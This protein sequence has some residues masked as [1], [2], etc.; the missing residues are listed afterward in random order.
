MSGQLWSAR[1]YEAHGR[2]VSDLGSP[3]VD[4]LEPRPGERIL[5]VGCGDGALTAR[6]VERGAAVVGVDASEDFVRAARERGLDARL[7]DARALTFAGEFDA[8]FSNAVLHW[9]D[10][11]EPVLEGVHRALRPGGRFVGE[12][13]GFGNVAAITTAMR[14]VAAR[15]R[16]PLS[17]PWRFP[18]AEAFEAQLAA[19]GFDDTRA[20][21]LP[22][23][24]A[25][26]SGMADWLRTFANGVF[27]DVAAAEREAALEEVEE[28]L[29]PSLRD[30]RGRW[31]ADYVRLRFAA[32][33]P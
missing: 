25:L 33:R 2:F 14:A 29:R 24:T 6:L 21:L 5:D 3:V 28:L 12:F 10:G 18:T 31:T 27:R 32:R 9:I 1:D 23:P 19:T 15:R 26:P 7:G 22:R 30:E 4:L 20:W 13:G 11:L 17:L 8:A 16:W